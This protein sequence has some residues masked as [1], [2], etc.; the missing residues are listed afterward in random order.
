[1]IELTDTHTHLFL[2]EF[3]TDRAEMMLRTLDKGVTKCF[4]PNIDVSTISS[5]FKTCYEFPSACY[6][7]MGLHP[8][9]VNANYESQLTE[10][11]DW[12]SKRKFYG[13]GEIG[14]DLFHDITF[15][16]QQKTAFRIQVEWAKEMNLPIIIHSRNSF[17]EVIDIVTELHDSRLKGIFHC[18]SGTVEE[19]K[20]VMELKS[21]KMG[22]GGV[23]TYKKNSLPQVLSEVPL[24]S[25]VLE[26]DSPYL[27]PTPF[28]GK[29]NESSYLWYVAEKLSEIYSLSLEKIAEV[30]TGNAMEVF[31]QV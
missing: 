25:I 19:A 9:S 12:F 29:R 3:D 2:P 11:K 7:M 23:V 24:S 10:I 30:T 15:A 16:E 14:I 18:F 5:L 1:V 8:C 31:G 27:T 20:R 26:T 17:N 4:L 13:V 22:I 28:R 6:P 21:F